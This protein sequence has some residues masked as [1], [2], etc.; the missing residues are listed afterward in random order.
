ME[1]RQNL[2]IQDEDTLP[3]GT[4]IANLVADKLQNGHFLGYRHRDYCGM[5]MAADENQQ[6]FY[7]EIYDGDLDAPEIFE[8]RDL[9]VSWLSVQSTESLARVDDEKFYAGNQVITRKRLLE[10]IQ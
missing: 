10:F 7:G 4:M 1:N 6:F 8:N 3:F 9:F 2:D 5:G